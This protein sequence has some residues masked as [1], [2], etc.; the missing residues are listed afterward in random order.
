MYFPVF[1]NSVEY[2]SII[3]NII[4]IL[5]DIVIHNKHSPLII[6]GD[7]NL[8]FVNGL[9]QCHA[10]NNFLASADVCRCHVTHDTTHTFVCE[11]RNAQSLIDHFLVMK[12]MDRN[13]PIALLNIIF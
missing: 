10:F 13:V 9:T 5:E 2:E 3:S 4:S 6:G 7:F 8:E 12:F 1:R 11:S